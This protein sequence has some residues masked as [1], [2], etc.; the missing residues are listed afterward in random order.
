MGLRG[1]SAGSSLSLHSE[2]SPHSDSN[3]CATVCIVAWWALQRCLWHNRQITLP[4]HHRRSGRLRPD[5]AHPPPKRVRMLPQRL[6][7]RRTLYIRPGNIS[8]RRRNRGSNIINRNTTRGW[9]KMRGGS[10]RMRNKMRW[11]I[12]YSRRS[13]HRQRIRVSR[14]VVVQY[15]HTSI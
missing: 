12:R 6:L 5:G 9:T 15:S 11:T 3:Q 2:S 1:L 7:R 14:E 10:R 8:Q 13:W 4:A